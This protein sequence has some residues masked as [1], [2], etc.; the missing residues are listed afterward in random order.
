MVTV[1]RCEGCGDE[2]PAARG[3]PRKRCEPCGRTWRRADSPKAIEALQAQ[4]DARGP[5][6]TATEDAC[7]RELE[8]LPEPLRSSAVAMAALELAR[9]I[10]LGIVSF[11]FQSGLV[12]ELRDCMDALQAKA[13][14]RERDGLDQLAER[15]ASRR[16]AAAS[17]E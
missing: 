4:Q 14:R 16:G 12:K 1:R 9:S 3:R 7:R 17:G 11:R 8:Q 13:P 6:G 5:R 15:R 10:D 2:L